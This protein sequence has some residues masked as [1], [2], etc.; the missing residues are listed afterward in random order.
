MVC[1]SVSDEYF[2]FFKCT[3]PSHS[4]TEQEASLVLARLA[5]LVS[6][7]G[8]EIRKL[9]RGGLDKGSLLPE[10]GG[11]ELV[12]EADALESGHDKVAEG[13][14]RAARGSVAVSNTSHLQELLGDGGSDDASATGG[15][16]QADTDRT[17]LARDLLGDS[18][19]LTELVTPVATAN[20]DDVKLGVC[21]STNREGRC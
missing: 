14:G 2:F 13:A 9:L 4:V 16:N 11:E 12:G 7:L 21:I 10:I 18:V 15:G 1:F 5:D 20:G 17:A 6:R 19:G 8:E 3:L